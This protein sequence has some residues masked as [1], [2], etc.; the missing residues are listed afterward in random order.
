VNQR[1][2]AKAAYGLTGLLVLF[3]VLEAA[4]RIGLVPAR[5][6]PPAS[7]IVR[8]LWREASGGAFWGAVA[9]TAR[10]GAIG[11]AIAF[12]AGVALGMVIGSV[13]ALRAATGSTIEILRPIPSVALIPLVVLEFS[14]DIRST[15]VL[16]VYA[17]FWQVLIQ[18][19]YGVADVDPIAHDTARSYGLGAWARLRHVTWP[20]ALPY[21]MTGLRLSA[22]V[23]LILAIT[24]ELIIG[25]PGLGR[26]IALA[27]SGGA[28]ATL[29]GLVVATGLIGVL[30][31]VGV[32]GL[33][34]RVLAWHPA[35][36]A[37]IP[38]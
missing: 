7:R 13:P 31:N 29:Y 37:E 22:A 25:S 14:T 20:T 27:Q 9:D 38:A 34:R 3:A 35:V 24:G 26:E 32:R 16:V 5:Y 33:E 30:I 23:A 28:V 2:A 11:L 19:L 12:C 1:P 18:V 21:V 10:T 6:L 4:P 15:V 8:A 17:C 36:R